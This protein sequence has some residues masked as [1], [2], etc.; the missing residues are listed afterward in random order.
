VAYLLDEY[1][2]PGAQLFY[3]GDDDKDEEAFGVIKS[4][5]GIAVL[6]ASEPRETRADHRLKSPRDVRRWLEMLPAIFARSSSN[7]KTDLFQ[8]R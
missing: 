5:G 7:T 1:P 8:S 3:L 2:L 4:R 6:V